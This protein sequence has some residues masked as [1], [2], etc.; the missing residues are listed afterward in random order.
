MC[1]C[2]L[3]DAIAKVQAAEASKE[4]GQ[5]V[6]EV[7][8]RQVV[9]EGCASAHP[10]L[11]QARLKELQAASTQHIK[12]TDARAQKLVCAVVSGAASAG[13]SRLTLRCAS[14]QSEI[15]SL[16]HEADERARA[17]EAEL[18]HQRKEITEAFEKVLRARGAPHKHQLSSPCRVSR[19]WRVMTR[20]VAVPNET[21]CSNWKLGKLPKQSYGC[22]RRGVTV[23]SPQHM[24]L[25]AVRCACTQLDLEIEQKRKAEAL[26]K[27]ELLETQVT[28]AQNAA[29]DIEDRAKRDARA[30]DDRIAELEREKV[31]ASFVCPRTVLGCPVH[32]AAQDELRAG[33]DTLF[34]EYESKMGKLL[35]QLHA[36]ERVCAEQQ[37]K[38]HSDLTAK[39]IERVRPCLR[40]LRRNSC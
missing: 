38:A 8:R 26:A 29:K 17:H 6:A 1:P 27:V 7:R 21:W 30:R 37:T 3:D 15:E 40:C 10:L 23:H 11:F 25:V 18:Q 9:C 31:R 34:N 28:Q 39:Q 22:V 13:L 24:T 12:T 36:V 4:Q 16:R 14:Q 32:A 20:I 5:I 2:Q 35:K 33:K 19:R